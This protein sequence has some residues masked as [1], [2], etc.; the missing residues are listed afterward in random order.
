MLSTSSQQFSHFQFLDFP[1]A[2]HSTVVASRRSRVSSVFASVTHCTYS[3]LWLYGKPSNVVSAFLFFFTAA[4]KKLGTTNSFLADFGFGGAGD[5][6]S[7]SLRAIA[8]FT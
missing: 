3:F 4:R 7:S 2:S 5:F 6:S 8:F 1:S